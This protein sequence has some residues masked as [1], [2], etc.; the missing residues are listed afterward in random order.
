MLY[1]RAAEGI[2]YGEEFGGGEG[3]FVAFEGEEV[4]FVVFDAGLEL[5]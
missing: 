1:Q 3:G 4:G 5:I 2:N